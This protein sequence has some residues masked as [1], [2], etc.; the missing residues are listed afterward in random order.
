MIPGERVGACAPVECIVWGKL[1]TAM[2]NYIEGRMVAT[3]RRFAVVVSR[4][5]AFISERLLE[6]AIDSLVRHGA[7]SD[8][9]DVVRV[10]GTWE[11]PLV[12]A[13]AAECGRYDA[14]VCVGCLIRGATTHYDHIAAECSKGIASA[15]E[16][17]GVPITF[18]VVTAETIEQAIERAGSKAGNKGSEAAL[19]AIEMVD[20]V[21]ALDAFPPRN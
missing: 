5:N 15:M 10:P 4:F 9:I 13:K 20:V 2:P 21:R 11:I 14:V 6:G 8:A 12:A 1:A 7:E 18:G 17:T 3:G 16:R 19:A